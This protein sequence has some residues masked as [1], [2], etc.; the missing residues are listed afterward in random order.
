MGGGGGGGGGSPSRVA[1]ASIPLP[2]P[3]DIVSNRRILPDQVLL[4]MYVSSHKRIHPPA[5]MVTPDLEGAQDIIHRWS[6]F[7]QAES[8]VVHMRDHYPNYFRVSMAAR[9]E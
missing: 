7:N 2:R 8:P 1:T 4:S 9:A 6:P 3:T 5:G